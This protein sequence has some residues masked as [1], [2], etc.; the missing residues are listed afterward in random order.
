MQL[1]FYGAA[2][3]VTGS[4]ILVT[5]GDTR[6]LVDCGLFQ[7]V[8]NERLRNRE[9]FPFDPT[10]IDALLLTHAHL[11]HSGLAPLL[12]KRGFD[13]PIRCSRGT[14]ALLRVLWLDAARLN[15]E[16]ARWANQRGYSKHHPAEPLFTVDDA[17]R[18]LDHVEPIADHEPLVIG[19]LRARWTPVGHILGACAV[20]LADATTSVLFSGDVGRPEDP[21]MRAPE[22]PPPAEHLVIESTYG[23]RVHPP[24]DVLEAL[25]GIV[26]RTAQRGGV[27]LVPAFAVG[28]AQ[29][30]VHLLAQLRTTQ[31]IPKLPITLDSPMAIDVSEIH[32]AHEG[33]HRL[34]RAEWERDAKI[35]ELLR[36]PEDSR[37]LLDRGGPRIVISASGMATGGRVLH[38]LARLLPEPQHTV[39][40]AGFQAA[41]TRG[42]AL[43]SGAES[44]KIHGEHVPVRAEI[45]KLDGLSAHADRDELLGWLARFPR[46]P[47]STYVVHGE[48]AA[49][50]AMRRAIADR[51]GW[52]AVVPRYGMIV[53][54]D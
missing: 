1:A 9:P 17:N 8:K 13:G 38:H 6:V 40:L 36:D 14:A 53:E 20:H 25:A 33:D 37:H 3:T 16:D 2:E 28:R 27:L 46:A 49:A 42:D 48:P 32:R 31:R 34:T 11:D 43:A 12:V 54:L 51:F 21:I 41:G 22:V 39:L 52:R 50:D 23:N 10:T 29:L 45:V 26:T 35:V 24:I 18:A 5:S 15:E 7:G 4:K 19:A 47:R 30:L 44:V